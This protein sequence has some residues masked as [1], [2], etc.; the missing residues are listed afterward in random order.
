MSTGNII[1]RPATKDGRRTRSGVVVKRAVVEAREQARQIIADAEAEAAAL[2][3]SAEATAREL[4]EAAYHEG[5]EAA[6]AELNEHLLAAREER[7]VALEEVERDVLRLVVKLAEKVIGREIDSHEATL[8]DIVATAL[9]QARQHEMLTVR[10][11]PADLPYVQAHSERLD[12]AGRARF[13]D[14][15]ADPRV[16]H[17]GCIIESASGT[18]NAQLDV[19]LKVLERAL[20]ARASG[21][22]Q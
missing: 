4:R 22:A 17:G 11:N 5:I 19:Q 15:V 10:I 20:L 14:L 1:K 21:E 18:I 8:A 16:A 3:S 13:L 7:H 2:L 9:R 6:L 12:P